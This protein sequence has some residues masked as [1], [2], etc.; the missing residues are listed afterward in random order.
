MLLRGTVSSSVS[1][2]FQAIIILLNCFTNRAVYCWNALPE[3]VVNARSYSVFS[4]H[5]YA[6]I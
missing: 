6:W 4:Y 3:E 5:A 1:E 2:C